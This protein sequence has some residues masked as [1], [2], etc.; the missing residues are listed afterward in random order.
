M[1]Q[2]IE[3]PRRSPACGPAEHDAAAVGHRADH[4]EVRADQLP[5]PVEVVRGE[6]GQQ[7]VV[8]AARGREVERV[9]ARS[10]GQLG[11]PRLD[12]ELAQVDLE[13]DPARRRR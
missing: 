8:L 12:R 13:P 1:T 7:L 5:R 11:D 10:P 2:L 6:R 9:E 3:A 4:R